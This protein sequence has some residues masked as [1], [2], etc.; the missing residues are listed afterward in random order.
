[1]AETIRHELSFRSQRTLPSLLLG[2][3]S[4]VRFFGRRGGTSYRV[5]CFAD[6]Q[7]AERVAHGLKQ[8]RARLGR[9]V[10]RVHLDWTDQAIVVTDF[11][12]GRVSETI[13]PT[14]IKRCARLLARVH[15]VDISTRRQ[16]G[17]MRGCFIHR[18]DA[19]VQ[20]ARRVPVRKRPEG[21]DRWNDVYER[22]RRRSWPRVLIHGDPHDENFVWDRE[23]RPALI[24]WDLSMPGAPHFDLSYLLYWRGY[25]LHKHHAVHQEGRPRAWQRTIMTVLAAYNHSS[26]GGRRIELRDLLHW[27]G[28]TNLAYV[29]F[30]RR[31]ETKRY[32][33]VARWMFE[34][35]EH[36]AE[37]YAIDLFKSRSSSGRLP[38][39]SGH[40]HAPTTRRASL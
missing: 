6:R 26:R 17:P 8:A 20:S 36:M 31:I 10:P 33:E 3:G 32:L 7:E 30:G 14:R 27:L 11:V 15:N 18:L 24:D 35:I 38:R 39:A 22:V 5:A 37:E 23:G 25:A 19:L 29:G 12:P 16:L 34:T 13:G 40:A 1:M 2:Q 4:D 9:S 28:C 21:H